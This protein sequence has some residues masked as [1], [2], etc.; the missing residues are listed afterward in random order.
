C[1]PPSRSD[2]PGALRRGPD[3]RRLEEAPPVAPAA[4]A[5]V[6][7]VRHS[8]RRLESFKHARAGA[9]APPNAVARATNPTRRGD[10]AMPGPSDDIFLADV[11]LRELLAIVDTQSLVPPSFSRYHA[12][13]SPIRQ[14]DARSGRLHRPERRAGHVWK[15]P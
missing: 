12:R 4:R 3:R 14:F 8:S 10:R 15:G 1:A 13:T 5:C 6:G 11:K 7:R 2:F 9:R